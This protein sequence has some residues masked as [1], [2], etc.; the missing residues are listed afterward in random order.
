MILGFFLMIILI[1]SG[2]YGFAWDT[3][4]DGEPP[5]PAAASGDTLT[6]APVVSAEVPLTET[7]PLSLEDLAEDGTDP[8]NEPAADDAAPQAA[9]QERLAT[10]QV[11][12][13]EDRLLDQAAPPETT[14]EDS[15]ETAAATPEP[16]PE[17]ED[18]AAAQAEVLGAVQRLARHLKASLEREDISGMDALF[19]RDWESFFED[20]NAITAVVRPENVQVSGAQA[21]VDVYLDLDYQDNEDQRRQSARS[22]RWNLVRMGD[23]WVLTR[24]GAQ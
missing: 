8:P 6:D 12:D 21:T 22:H 1:A 15:T 16:A 4:E 23:G 24:V 9:E 3:S 18:T 2:Y 7:A 11:L 10:E 14:S 20:A 17:E 19:Y 5:S 13:A